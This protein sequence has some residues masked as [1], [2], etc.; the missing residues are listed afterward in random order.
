LRD[1]QEIVDLRLDGA[2]PAEEPGNL[3]LEIH[4]GD[5]AI[6]VERKPDAVD[7]AAGDHVQTTGIRSA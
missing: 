1:R 2:H 7:S 6:V 3:E 5:Q 4:A